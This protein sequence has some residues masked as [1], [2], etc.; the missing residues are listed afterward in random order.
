MKLENLSKN[1]YEFNLND[2][3]DLIKTVA[4]VEYKKINLNYIIDYSEVLSIATQTI[5]TLSEY[6][7]F[8]YY[9][10]SYL[11]TAIKWAIRNEVRRRSKWYFDKCNFCEGESEFNSKKMEKALDKRRKICYNQSDKKI[12]F[13]LQHI[14]HNLYLFDYNNNLKQLKQHNLVT[15]L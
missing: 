5:Y 9:N 2:Y 12:Y 14:H 10:M 11:S 13:P 8:K 15:V 3:S 7:E 6:P 4:K 1:E